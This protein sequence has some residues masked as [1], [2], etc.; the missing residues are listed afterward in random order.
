MPGAKVRRPS[1]RRT[2]A[3]N[4]V[5]LA[6]LV[7]GLDGD[8]VVIADDRHGTRPLSEALAHA[9]SG[10]ADAVSDCLQVWLAIKRGLAPLRE[11]PAELDSWVVEIIGRLADGS[12]AAEALRLGYLSWRPESRRARIMRAM[13]CREV[14]SLCRAGR[15]RTAAIAEVAAVHDV[16]ERTVRRAL[17]GRREVS[18]SRH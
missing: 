9:R 8:Q 11:V 6:Q 4:R 7:W 17:S 14:A 12:E 10:D 1:R 16:D 3:K 2:L 15:S 18:P 13:F 5:S